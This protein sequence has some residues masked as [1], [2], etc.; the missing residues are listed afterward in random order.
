MKQCVTE[1]WT[2]LDFI[3]YKIVWPNNF[4]GEKVIIRVFIPDIKT[5]LVLRTK[6]IIEKI[7]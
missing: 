7:N 4:I 5:F 2:N 1:Q 6:I 3:F